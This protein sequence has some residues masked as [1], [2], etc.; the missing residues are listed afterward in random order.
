[1][2]QGGR[3]RRS[4]EQP[5]SAFGKALKEYLRRVDFTQA[6]LAAESVIA[7][8][9]LSQMV[10]GKRTGGPT[11]RRDLR[12]IIKVLHRKKALVTLEEANR[13]ITTIPAVSPLDDRDPADL[14]II[15]L[16][17]AQATGEQQKIQ[18]SP[19]SETPGRPVRETKK[20]LWRRVVAVLV[21]L[22]II[23]GTVASVWAIFSRQTDGCSA[24]TNGVTLYVDPDYRGHCHTFA[25]G[26]YDLAEFGLDQNVSSLKDPDRAY[27]ITLT[28]RTNRPGYF[29]SDTPQ[30]P[31]DWNDQAHS[32]R[33]EKHRP[34]TCNSGA[35]GIIAFINTDYSEGC[36]FITANIPDLTPLNF[37]QVIVSIQFVG[38][39][40]NTRQ[41]VIYKQPNYK[42][43]CGAY[44]QNQSDLL[45][46][47]RLALSV[48]VL[49]FTPPTPVPIVPGTHYAGNVAPQSMLSP[50]SASAVVDGNLQTEW[51]GGHMT[52]LDLS[53]AF[54]VTIH[55]VVVW[56][57]KQNNPDNNQVN[58]LKLSFGD[59]T[60]TGSIDMK[61]SGPRCADITFPEKTITQLHIIPLDASG[62]N[63][64]SEVEVWA[65]TGPQYSN[66]TCVNKVMV[67]QTVPLLQNGT[68]G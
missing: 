23:G 22:V 8:K 46:C 52:Q 15:K 65:T 54:P 2:K 44:W 37:D 30:L 1:M 67:S 27:H 24:N 10:K 66:N 58:K 16:F 39:Y 43:E 50:G 62:N 14:E 49:P 42:D 41:L 63:G 60:S 33:V 64:Y 4:E 32:L 9:T 61:S 56:D 3:P 45:Q 17:D 5:D 29:D 7:E 36:L 19:I 34:T 13:L 38:S 25:P 35:N 26:D 6:E 28:D 18:P 21:T 68:M 12:A 40:Q 59:G 20:R 55:R 51:I 11:F 31:V 57:R 47:A 53:W 48:Q